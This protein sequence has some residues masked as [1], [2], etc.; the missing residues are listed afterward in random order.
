MTGL[1]CCATFWGGDFFS[2][3]SGMNNREWWTPGM[4]RHYIHPHSLPLHHTLSLAG[5]RW[6]AAAPW[7]L[8]QVDGEVGTKILHHLR[9]ED[10]VS[11]LMPSAEYFSQLSCLPDVT[12]SG[13]SSQAW[14]TLSM[15]ENNCTHKI[16]VSSGWGLL[17]STETWTIIVNTV[18][19]LMVVVAFPC[20]QG[21]WGIWQI[22]PHL[23]FLSS[24]KRRSVHGH[25]FL[26]SMPR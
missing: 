24:L 11:L 9:T 18:W 4:Q 16:L 12:V 6:P 20:V 1:A 25:N 26:L 3:M 2:D 7:S 8:Q 19:M 21:L 10:Q 15:Q 17:S 22:I 14:C 23:F 5:C 13:D